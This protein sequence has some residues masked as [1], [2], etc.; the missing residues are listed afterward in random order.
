MSIGIF[1]FSD[2]PDGAAV[3]VVGPEA[4]GERR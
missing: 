2:F 1:R 3:I 4:L